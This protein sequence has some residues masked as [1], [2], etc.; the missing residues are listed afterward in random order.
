MKQQQFKLRYRTN[1]HYKF[2]I[3]FLGL[4][5]LGNINHTMDPMK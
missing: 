2:V 4:P 5:T 3:A 1:Y